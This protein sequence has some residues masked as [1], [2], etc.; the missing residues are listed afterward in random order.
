MSRKLGL[1]FIILVSISISLS[2]TS[3][4]TVLDFNDLAIGTYVDNEYSGLG[5][6]FLPGGVIY[7][8]A[9]GNVLGL[10]TGH[11]TAH[12]T[13]EVYMVGANYNSMSYLWLDAYRS[14][15]TLIDNVKASSLAG[16]FSL[17]TS[18]PI[19]KVSIHDS[20]Y[21]FTIDNFMFSNNIS[22]IPEESTIILSGTGILFLAIMKRKRLDAL[23]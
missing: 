17:S 2:S 11:I 7:L 5:V 20:G 13:G 1:L 3:Q 12:F 14:D 8:F 23:C 22:A 9:P 21:S 4:A 10:D 6:T 18:E 15:G 16:Y 19:A